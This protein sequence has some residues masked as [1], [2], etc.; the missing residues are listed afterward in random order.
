MK[1]KVS[2][3]SKLTSI[4]DEPELKKRLFHEP[5]PTDDEF[6]KCARSMNYYNEIM[7]WRNVPPNKIYRVLSIEIKGSGENP[8]KP[9]MESADGNIFKV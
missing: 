6:S 7:K 1:R 8:Y 5:F 3:S 2:D 9:M 4:N